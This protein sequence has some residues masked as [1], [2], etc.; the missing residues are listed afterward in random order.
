MKFVIL[1]ILILVLIGFFVV[2]WKAR[3]NWRWFHIVAVILNMILAIVFLFPTAGVLKSRQAWHKVKEE[4]EV[5]AAKAELEQEQLKLGDPTNPAAGKGYVAVADEL[6]EIA[7]EAGRVWRS[8]AMQSNDLQGVVLAQNQAASDV[9]PELAGGVAEAGGDGEAVA[10][11]VAP[12]PLLPVGLVVYGFGEQAMPNSTM[13]LPVFYLGEFQ[14]TASTP[15]QVTVVPTMPLEPAQQ[16]AIS[17][18]QARSWSLYELLPLDGHKMFVR[19]G[20]EQNDESQFGL[21]DE[22]LLNQLFSNRVKPESLQRYIR[23]GGRSLP[24]D[25]PASRW[26]QVEFTKKYKIEVD[27]PEQ[28]G[29]LDGGFFDG[30]GR[31][32]DSRLQRA[33]DNEVPFNVGDVITVKEEAA[34]MLMDEGVAKLK[35]QFYVRPLNDYRFGLRSVRLQLDQLATRKKEVEDQSRVLQDA[36]AATDSMLT[37][38]QAIKLKLEQDLKQRQVEKVAIREYHDTV[39]KEVKE[40]RERL[41]RLYNSNQKL[42]QELTHIELAIQNRIDSLSL[43]P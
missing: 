22:Q 5:R 38:N 42:E 32:V 2:V 34:D 39:E 12:Q 21:M 26:T 37:S 35:N 43:N 24:D 27:S 41:V 28:R 11:P 7:V 31:A 20:S 10:G 4:L 6:A 29:A 1:A 36:I 13:F 15:T 33:E 25:P 19:E 9:P 14:V 18:G 17:S 8:L 23:D 3:H 40:T 16:D 30:N